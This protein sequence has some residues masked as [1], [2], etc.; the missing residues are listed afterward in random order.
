[1]WKLVETDAG[2]VKRMACGATIHNYNFNKQDNQISIP[3]NLCALV[4]VMSIVELWKASQAAT[5]K[6]V[7]GKRECGIFVVCVEIP[8]TAPGSHRKRS[9]FSSLFNKISPAC[10]LVFHSAAPAKIHCVRHT[11]E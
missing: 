1:M 6:N 11:K 5:I 7:S 10:P 2:P 9:K 3:T 4:V 8:C